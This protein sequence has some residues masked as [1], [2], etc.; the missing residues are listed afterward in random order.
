VIPAKE[1]REGNSARARYLRAKDEVLTFN[2]FD[3]GYAILHF[4][5]GAGIKAKWGRLSHTLSRTKNDAERAEI[6]RQMNEIQENACRAYARATR[7]VHLLRGLS[8]ALDK[9]PESEEL[10]EIA[11]MALPILEQAVQDFIKA[12]PIVDSAGPSVSTVGGD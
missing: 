7:G 12:W 5:K 1:G 3:F 11:L 2:I 10:L 8:D 6:A 9:E 4:R